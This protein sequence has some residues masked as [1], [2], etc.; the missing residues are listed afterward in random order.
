M[1]STK[2]ATESRR[3]R[4][5]RP[6]IFVHPPGA[7]TLAELQG[8]CGEP[9]LFDFLLDAS[10]NLDQQTGELRVGMRE[11][12]RRHHGMSAATAY[13]RGGEIQDRGIWKKT[14]DAG[15]HNYSGRPTC[16]YRVDPHYLPAL[17]HARHLFRPDWHRRWRT[18][19]S[20]AATVFF[21]DETKGVADSTPPYF[22]PSEPLNA[23][24]EERSNT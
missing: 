20:E 7:A 1:I 17:I 2:P 24:R 14:R 9:E 19:P 18:Q 22:E 5:D 11:L 10:E 12:G 8:A 21:T 23:A 13:R 6:S 4:R 16:L 3:R 15:R